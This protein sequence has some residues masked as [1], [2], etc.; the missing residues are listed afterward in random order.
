VRIT[1]HNALEVTFQGFLDAAPDAMVTVASDGTIQL[2]NQQ[3]ERLFGYDRAELVGQPVEVLVPERYRGGHPGQ[4]GG[5]FAEPRPRPMAAGVD[6]FG[7]RKDGSEFPAEISL[8]PVETTQGRLVTAAIRDATE[9]RRVEAKFKGLLE[10]A[11]DAVVIVNRSGEIVLVNSQTEKLFGYPRAELLG[12]SVELL[13]PKRFREGHPAHRSGYFVDPRVRS[14]GSGIELFGLRRDGSEFPVE[15]SL[16]P[17]E[18]EEGTL[19]SSA[20]RDITDRKRAEDKFRSLLEAAPDAIVIVNR[21]G[22]IVLVNAQTE[23][24]F[25]YPREEILGQLVEKLVPERFREKHPGHRADFFAAPKVRSMGS[26]LE[27]YGLRK[28]GTEF[29]IE[30]SLSPLETEDGTLVSSAIRDITERKKAE[31]KFRG[32][33]ESAPDAMV[34]VNNQGRILL[35]NA[36]TEKLFQYT[37]GELVGQWVEM[38]IP[39]RFRKRHPGYR[40]SFFGDPKA[41]SMGTGLELFGLRKDGQEFPIEISLSP[42]ETEEGTLVSSAIRDITE[43]KRAE[44]QF[45]GL[46]ESAPDATVIVNQRGQIVLVNSQTERLFDYSRGDLMGQSVEIL[47]PERFRNAHPGHRTRYF[48]DPKVR[49]MGSNLELYGRRRDGSEFPV[50]IS[51]SPLE[52]EGGVLVSS[53]IRDVTERRKAEEQRF[54]L[55]AIVDSSDDAIIGKTLDGIILTWNRGAERLFGY[56]AVEAIGQAITLLLPPGKIGEE[57][58]IIVRIQ[59]GERVQSFETVRRRKDGRD[60]DVSVTISAIHDSRGNVIGASK[61]ARD[62][63]ERKRAEEALARAKEAAEAASRELESFSYSVAH[64]LRA[65]LRGIDGFS[66]VLL[67][68]YADK[69]DQEGQRYLGRVRESAQHMAQLIESLLSLARVTRDDV[70][71]EDVDLSALAR[72]IAERLKASQPE[73]HVDVM[74][75]EG[76]S[77]EGDARLLG[78]VLEN[79]FSNAWKFTRNQPAARI[80]LGCQRDGREDVFFV[81]DNGAGFDM[82]F[83]AKLFG[84]FQR[85]HTT[86]EFEGTGIG[87][88]TVQRIV[89]RHAGRIWAEAKVGH[90]ATFF[91]TFGRGI[92]END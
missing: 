69:L 65:P 10:A 83:A 87:L 57:P 3:A 5:Y 11:P 28:D 86:S 8:A 91:F 73:R 41:R 20:I 44:Q 84:V 63:S 1:D 74:I 64:D 53:T 46:L 60:V 27:L 38:L 66:Q 56:A 30:I 51:L 39:E 54:Q 12:K 72:Q 15:I 88:A 42:L 6:L 45:R 2:V 43:R 37:R 29:P 78:L 19:V 77:V 33:L 62:I 47:V 13:V 52:T 26:G 25:G 55:A 90:G 21:Y 49:S 79:L 17:L 75:G 67:E 70:R 81:R 71:R 4:R 32:L 58:E 59:R 36:Q 82:T 68:D 40:T 48:G 18:T 80:E 24:L 16:S 31:D 34:I 50:E 35:V 61:L 22:N 76:F 23:K 85:L 7:L 89:T 14:M 92:G 9:R